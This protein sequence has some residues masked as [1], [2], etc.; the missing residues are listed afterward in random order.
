VIFLSTAGTVLIFVLI[1]LVILFLLVENGIYRITFYN[2]DE[3]KQARY[4]L[5]A[6][7][8]YDVIRDQMTELVEAAVAVPFEEVYTT[9]YD[10][11]NLYA[12]YYSIR[13]G[14][15]LIIMFHGWKG[16]SLRDMAGAHKIAR[17]HGY[18]I[19]LVDERAHGN[20]AGHRI[21][22]GVKER[23]DAKTWVDY[24]IKRFG[25]DTEIILSGVSM[26]GAVVLMASDLDLPENVKGII[27]DSPFASPKSIICKVS[28]DKGIPGKI[29]WPFISFAARVFAHFDPNAAS[30]LE[31]VRHTKI[32][33][34]LIHGTEDRFVPCE[35]S[36]QIRD[37]CSAPCRLE[38]FEGAMH[39]VSYCIDTDRYT[40]A[41]LEFVSEVTD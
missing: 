31:S 23:F 16:G 21:T 37:N 38:I 5:P 8:Q 9:S 25:E 7:D 12:R 19:L 33:V 1:V 29:S 10:G 14:A 41:V 6:S 27:A 17:E 34:L 3:A 32:P 2:S 11:L 20:S 4:K 24:S 15:P 39:G 40:R 22:F 35:M 13:E 26:G 28:G 30:S 18:N 36:R